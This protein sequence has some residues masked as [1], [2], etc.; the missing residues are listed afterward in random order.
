[1]VPALMNDVLVAFSLVTRFFCWGIL[2]WAVGFGILYW[3]SHRGERKMTSRQFTLFTLILLVIAA[4]AFP[5]LAFH[6]IPDFISPIGIL[7]GRPRSIGWLLAV[8]APILV[9]IIVS[10]LRLYKW[11]DPQNDW[12]NGNKLD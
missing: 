1:M 3:V 7:Q 10:I 5:L 6:F 9:I 11:K 12:E 2:I 4:G 8:E